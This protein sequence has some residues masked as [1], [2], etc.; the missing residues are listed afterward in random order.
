MV[1]NIIDQLENLPDKVK[2]NPSILDDTKVQNNL[3]FLK[4]TDPFKFELIFDKLEL[5]ASIKRALLKNIKSIIKH[6][7]PPGEHDVKAKEIFAV[8]G[9]SKTDIFKTN[10]DGKY[11]LSPTKAANAIL[12]AG[13]LAMKNSSS[14]I[15]RYNP[16]TGIY[17]PDGKQHVNWI[18]NELGEDLATIH[19]KREITNKI[20]ETLI[21]APVEFDLDPYL[22]HAEDGILDL[23]TGENRS[24]TPGDYITFKYHAQIHNANPDYTLFLWFLCSTLQNPRDVLRVIDMI[25]SVPIRVPFDFFA[26]LIGEGENGKGLLE[27]LLVYMVTKE[28]FTG[29]KVK[30][31][32]RSQFAAG[33]LLGSDLWIMSEVTTIGEAMNFIKGVTSGEPLDSDVKHD[34]KRAKG[35]PTALLIID[36][37]LAFGFRDNSRGRKRRFE[38]VDYFNTFGDGSNDRPIDKHLLEKL[39][40]PEVIAG[41]TQIIAARAPSLIESKTIYGWMSKDEQEKR[42][43]IQQHPE[44]CFCRDCLSNEKLEDISGIPGDCIVINEDGKNEY[45]LTIDRTYNEYLAYCKIFNVTIPLEKIPFGIYVSK[46]YN[47]QSINTRKV[48]TQYRYYPGLYLTKSAEQVNV[49]LKTSFNRSDKSENAQITLDEWIDNGTISDNETKVLKDVVS[50]IEKMY[51]FI[52]SHENKDVTFDKYLSSFCQ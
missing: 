30:E 43:E 27:K 3:A 19:T 41:I 31:A 39:T 47:I 45:R 33:G 34:K 50:T 42:Y 48:K 11:I 28:R 5:K 2:K 23:Q 16:D 6:K 22:F 10:S 21:M 13:M 46:V 18:I 51:V 9:V 7:T 40:R 29:I 12:D 52:N 4:Q 25:V 35:I 38:K 17:T 15:Y 36:A 49:N 8:E 20:E 26:V 32:Q 24:Y 37:N 14:D 1:G 44:S